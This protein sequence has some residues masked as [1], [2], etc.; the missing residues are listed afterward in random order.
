VEAPT[1]G[2]VLLAGVLLKMG[3]YGMLRFNLGLFPEQSR[4]NAWWIMV[5]A[6]IGI[7][8]G[9]LVAMVQPNMKKL[10]AYSS[11]SHLGF[12]VLGIFSFT[13]AGL[14]GATYVMLA[15]GV[16]TG[17]L[18]M[19]AG[20]LY[21]RRHTYEIAEFGGLATPMPVYATFFLFIV[22]ASAGL[23]LLNGFVGEFLVLSGAFRARAVYGI[24]GATGVI[25]SACYLLWMYQ[26]VFYG[27]VTHPVN[28]SLPD[29]SGRERA[30]L[31]P[32]A[33]VALV[34][35]VAPLLWLNAIDPSVQAVLAPFAELAS[36]MVRR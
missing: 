29:L 32:A 6:L 34:M 5:L 15:H 18:F 8:Y 36:K 24:L 2:S 23:P 11:I 14:D 21:E 1:A 30:A 4:N 16:S 3:T 10:I 13:Q 19:L 9:A 22:L 33:V 17:A 28:L 26:R 27:K 31:W 20:I 7:V 35:G 25:W 12:V